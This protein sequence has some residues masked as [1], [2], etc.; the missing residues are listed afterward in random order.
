MA[1]IQRDPNQA[2]KYYRKAL[3]LW[4]NYEHALNNLGNLIK[5]KGDFQ[6]AEKMFEKRNGVDVR[7][8]D[9]V[10]PSSSE[11]L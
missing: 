10:F 6:E 4:P 3:Q 5:T 9:V 8:V 1:K 11:M 2:E 7:S